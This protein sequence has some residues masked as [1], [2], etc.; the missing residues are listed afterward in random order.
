MSRVAVAGGGIAGLAAAYDLARLGA[1]PVLFEASSRLGGI[2]ETVREQ[3]F[4]IECGP[5]AWVTEKPWA[6]ELAVELGLAEQILSSNDCWR[7][8]YIVRGRALVPMPD[9]MRMMVPSQWAPL[10]ASPLFSWQARLAYLREFHRA[11]ELR[12]EALPEGE[13]ESVASFVRRHFGEEVTRTVAGPLL[14]GVFGGDV[15]QLSARAVMHNFLK[16]EREH[17]SLIRAVQGKQQPEQPV[18]STLARGLGTLIDRA[19]A[20]LPASAIRLHCEVTAVAPHEGKWTVRF[21]QDGASREDRFDQLILATPAHVTR[22]LM[23][24]VDP[25]IAGLLNLEATS[26]IVVALG[27]LP[28]SA[29]RLRIP[30]GFGFLEPP[31]AEAAGGEPPLLAAT[32]VD[33]KFSQRAPAGAVLL[34]GFFGGR[35]A[36]A[37][38]QE[39][40]QQIAALAH[41]Q[42]SRL[43]GPLPQP[44]VTVVRRWPR[45]LPQYTV[46]HV[47]RMEELA[48]RVA[49]HPGLHLTGNAYRGVGLPDLVRQGRAAARR[50]VQPAG[51]QR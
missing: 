50:L 35:H 28:A 38:L 44:D 29:A 9:G 20:T 8:T 34:R 12:A 43:L 11:D 27:F 4:V 32:F 1:E 17:G 30:R 25:E 16:M 40:D 18:F 13:D 42:L 24:P 5:D 23:E 39:P 48:A 37:L 47:D 36:P 7:R 6:H 22:R 10:F 3:G 14:A 31:T 51:G 2:V 21:A 49:H 15:E 46:G 41:R 33:Q 45:S 19:A 26:A